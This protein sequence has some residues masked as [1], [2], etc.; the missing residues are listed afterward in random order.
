MSFFLNL[1]LGVSIHFFNHIL[2][3]FKDSSKLPRFFIKKF[4]LKIR[5]V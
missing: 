4:L 3:N 5:I 1:I 2:K